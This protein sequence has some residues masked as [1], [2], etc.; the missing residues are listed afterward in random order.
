VPRRRPARA[1]AA[2]AL[3]LAWGGA[4]AAGPKQEKLLEEI[5]GRF[6]TIASVAADFTQTRTGKAFKKAQV[7]K[8]T[9]FSSRDGALVWKVTSPSP[10]VF[11]VKGSSATVS[12]P[13]LGYEKTYDLAAEAGLG[14]VVKSIFAIV[15][16]AGPGP[17]V[18]DYEVSAKGSWKKGWS[19]TLVPRGEALRA[20]IAR[21][22]LAIT[23]KDF[24]RSI[25]IVEG[26]G[27]TTVIDFTNVVL[28]PP[29][30]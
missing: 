14:V 21:I 7:Q 24:I 26:G 2:A 27:D 4:A 5:Y 13:E 1:L 22:V 28:A 8:G 20:A 12:Y 10:S 18:K 29:G 6:A 16:A 30:K 25:T 11:T 9:F 15:G 3:L 23:P 19:V 17:L